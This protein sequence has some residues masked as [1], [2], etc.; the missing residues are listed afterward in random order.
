MVIDNDCRNG[1]TGASNNRIHARPTEIHRVA[2]A[3][4]AMD[5]SGGSQQPVMFTGIV[6]SGSVFIVR[7][8]SILSSQRTTRNQG[9]M[10][11][12]H[13]ERDATMR[14]KFKS[15]FN[16]GLYALTLVVNTLGAMGYING[17]SQ[18]AVSDA[19]ATL[20]TPGPSTFA[21]WGV[22]YALLLISLLY[23]IVT[24]RQ[25]R[26]AKLIDTISV[27]FWVSCAANILWI[28]TFSYEWIG[29][30]TLLI[31]VYAVSLA[32]LNGRLKTP[33]GLGQKVNALAFGIYNGWLIIATVV[34]VS[35]Y[36]VKVKWNGF[37]LGADVWALVI[38][39]VALLLTGLIQ[40]RLRNAALTLPLA[41]AYLGIW[42]Q[43]QAQGLYAG[44]YPAIMTASLVIGILY[45]LIAVF[46]FVQNRFCLLPRPKA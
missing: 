46:V 42:Q 38:L 31:A 2:P 6:P 27:P 44:Q 39:I 22:I 1:Y 8:L 20:I 17:R 5:E 32:V 3:L 30:S 15:W 14:T 26:T 45:V 12:P 23:M 16:L 13:Q 29:I 9:T 37:G 34:N 11:N 43:H 28:I 24:H 40:L 4:T 36:L 18:K 25:A 7:L 21:I 33:D 41:W 35:A 10:L 19:Y